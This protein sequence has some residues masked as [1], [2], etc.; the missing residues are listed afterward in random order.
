MRRAAAFPAPSSVG[1]ARS[2]RVGVPSIPRLVSGGW[3]VCAGVIR[4]AS[5]A[6]FGGACLGGAP[7]GGMGS[8]VGV[9]RRW[10]PRRGMPFLGVGRV[11]C[12]GALFL[13]ALVPAP[14]P[15]WFLGGFLPPCG[16]S[17]GAL[18]LWVPALTG[19]PPMPSCLSPPWC[20][21]PS[22]CPCPSPSWCGGGGRGGVGR[23]RR[24]PR[25]GG[26]WPGAIGGGP[27]GC[28][29]GGVPGLHRGGGPP[30]PLVA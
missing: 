7:P 2:P 5:D 25:P 4:T 13:R 10:F 18:S 12:R 23:G 9:G 1:V 14:A 17:S 22:P 16:V 29:G 6:C 20:P 26:G 30:M 8:S 15:S 11:V 28:R 24:R 21:L 27:G 19:G 3:W